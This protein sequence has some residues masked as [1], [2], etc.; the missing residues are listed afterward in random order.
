MVSEAAPVA[1]EVIADEVVSE[2]APV[3]EEAAPI[4]EAVAVV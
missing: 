3:E 1:D 4:Q 2:A